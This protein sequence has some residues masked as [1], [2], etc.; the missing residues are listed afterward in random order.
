MVEDGEM[1]IHPYTLTATQH[2]SFSIPSW[3]TLAN[4]SGAP[5]SS[6]DRTH[7]AHPEPEPQTPHT[8]H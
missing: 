7:G 4:L 5:T 3:P 1:G 2:L 6:G 8:F